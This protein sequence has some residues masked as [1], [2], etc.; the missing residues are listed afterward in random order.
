MEL[1]PCG[2]PERFKLTKLSTELF[3]VKCKP[4]NVN[5]ETN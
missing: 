3:K 1:H 2:W 4:Y 5:W